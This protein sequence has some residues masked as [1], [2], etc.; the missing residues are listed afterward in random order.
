MQAPFWKLSFAHQQFGQLNPVPPPCLARV[1]PASR[2]R[3]PRR[4]VLV[5]GVARR[6]SRGRPRPRIA[7]FRALFSPL[8]DGHETDPLP[9][10]PPSGVI[11]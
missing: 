1:A 3:G 7:L 5:V 9:I 8:G 4:Q 11:G 10:S 6:L 2:R